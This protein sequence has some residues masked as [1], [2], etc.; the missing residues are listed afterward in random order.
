MQGEGQV[1]LPSGKAGIDKSHV[2]A[3]LREKINGEP[4]V[5]MRH[6]WAPHH[7]NDA[8]YPI[9]S[10]IWQGAGLAGGEPAA[11]RSTSSRR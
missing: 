3:A 4:H 11:A 1:I 2:L 9:V 6:Q 10:Q 5:T 7:V 8:F